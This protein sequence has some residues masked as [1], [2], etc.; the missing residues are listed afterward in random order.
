MDQ[1]TLTIRSGGQTG[2]D[3]GALDAARA[4][5]LPHTGWCP[6]GRLAEDGR[7]SSVYN[8]KET[9]TAL[10]R[11][12]TR[13]NIRDS[14][15]TVIFSHLPLTGG[16]KLTAGL[17]K[18]LHK[19]LMVIE[20]TNSIKGGARQLRQFIEAHQI[21][22]LNV[23]GP[24]A[25]TDASIYDFTKAVVTTALGRTLTNRQRGSHRAR[26]FRHCSLPETL[27]GA[28]HPGPRHAHR[29]ELRRDLGRD[30]RGAFTEG[31]PACWIWSA[32]YPST[33][34]SA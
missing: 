16:T 17:C 8:L 12:R 7:I 13:L 18:R 30:K 6:K 22:A 26:P 20:P 2:C 19:P 4:L 33:W 24:R 21:R 32:K 9:R 31:P 34:S 29:P 5:N 25:S 1:S 11:E 3:R 10:Y 14:D 15:A 23:A 28:V 27:P